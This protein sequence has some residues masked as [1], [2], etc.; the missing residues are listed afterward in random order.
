MQHQVCT[1]HVERK[2][3]YERHLHVDSLRPT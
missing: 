3:G 2:G 1:R